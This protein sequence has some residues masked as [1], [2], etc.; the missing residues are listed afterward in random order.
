VWLFHFRQAS[1]GSESPDRSE[2]S[3]DS[4]ISFHSAGQY[5]YDSTIRHLQKQLLQ[6]KLERE[7]ERERAQ[8]LI[9][10]LQEKEEQFQLFQKQ[11]A[12]KEKE[13]ENIIAENEFHVQKA[14][15]LEADV[16]ESQKKRAMMTIKLTATRQKL[17]RQ[18]EPKRPAGVF[19]L[20][21]DNAV[22]PSISELGSTRLGME[23]VATT[24]SISQEN[25][26]P[27]ELNANG[28]GQD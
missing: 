17:R 3:P 18:A 10:L 24:E 11:L 25:E 8:K 1:A 26:I 9:K 19:E 22:P 6:E 4:A 5:Q 12:E 13:K 27:Q 23:M 16:R 20:A 28:N 21:P 15:R 2:Q 14:Q 7:K